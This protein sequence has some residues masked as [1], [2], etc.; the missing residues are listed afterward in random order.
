MQII[1][2]FFRE[3]SGEFENFWLQYLE[4]VNVLFLTKKAAPFRTPLFQEMRWISAP[5]AIVAAAAVVAAAIVIAAAAIVKAAAAAAQ[6]DK[7]DDDDPAAISAE[8]VHKRTSF[9]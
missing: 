3:K 5:A 6:E 8:T 7:D 9:V 2:E 1:A 4:N